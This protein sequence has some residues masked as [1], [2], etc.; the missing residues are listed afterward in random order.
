M[1]NAMVDV[2]MIISVGTL[3]LKVEGL[4]TVLLRCSTAG[5]LQKICL[6]R[7]PIWSNVRYPNNVDANTGIAN[8]HK[9]NVAKELSL[10]KQLPTFY[11]FDMSIFFR[12]IYTAI[13]LLPSSLRDFL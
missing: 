7:M 12:N 8:S 1:R 11:N 5:F 3:C 4:L 10:Y 9:E 13:V 6:S 2:V